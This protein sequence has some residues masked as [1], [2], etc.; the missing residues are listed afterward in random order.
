[1]TTYLLVFVKIFLIQARTPEEIKGWFMQQGLA[2]NNEYPITPEQMK[3]LQR[4]K[5]PDSEN[6]K[7]LLACVFKKAQWLTDTGS[8]DIEKAKAIS[9]EEFANSPEKKENAAKLFEECKSVNDKPVA[10]GTKGCDRS[11]LATHCL[12]DNAPK[13]GFDL[14]HIHH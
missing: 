2:C 3:M 9:N 13:F 8:F 5:I 12:V 11:Y 4:H 10:D 14:K 7:C 6:V 1:M